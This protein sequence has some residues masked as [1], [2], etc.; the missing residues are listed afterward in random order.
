MKFVNLIGRVRGRKF[1]KCLEARHVRFHFRGWTFPIGQRR[2]RTTDI[3]SSRAVRQ[4]RK[5]MPKLNLGR[6]TLTGENKLNAPTWWLQNV[7]VCMYL[8]AGGARSCDYL[9]VDTA[10]RI[11]YNIVRSRPSKSFIKRRVLIKN[12]R[13]VESRGQ[14]SQCVTRYSKS[15]DDFYAGALYN[16]TIERFAPVICKWDNLLPGDSSSLRLQFQ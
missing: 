14:I 2:G 4:P 10:N 16:V 5:Q 7:C 3:I 8:R 15:S 11:E 13:A 6:A 12:V 1:A 9:S